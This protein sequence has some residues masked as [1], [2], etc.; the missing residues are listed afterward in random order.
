LRPEPTPAAGA[1]RRALTAHPQGT[2]PAGIAVTATLAAA[3]AGGL[4]C[5]FRLA[6]DLARL[7]LPEGP[8]G[9]RADGLWRHT[10]F[11]AFLAAPGAASYC[12]FNFS[13]AG[14]WAA[15]RFDGY[16]AGMRPAELAAPPRI[17]VQRT[18]G[19]LT[20]SAQLALAGLFARGEA[21]RVALAAVLEDERGALS[22]WALAHGPGAPDFHHAAGFALAA[23]VP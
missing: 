6:A 18:A 11:E 14:D 4:G 19:A 17:V 22:Y 8:G 10:C 16:R 2:A 7:R 5:E 12:E 20:L 15:Y 13:P 21:L 1:A 3:E 9:R 23:R